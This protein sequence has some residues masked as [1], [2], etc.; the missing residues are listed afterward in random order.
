[1]DP[2]VIV[3]YDPE[4]PQK[5]ER[6]RADILAAA[7]DVIRRIE[8]IGSTS[9]PG[10]AAKPVIDILIGV[11]ALEATMPVLGERLAPLGYQA[12]QFGEAGHG[13]LRRK[14]DGVRTHHVPVYEAATIEGHADLVFRDWLRTHQEDAAAYERLKRDMAVL[15]YENREAYVDSKTEIVREILGRARAARGAS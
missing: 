5:Y 3:E 4:W 11:D 6:A 2:I 15:H 7:G 14:V 8:H 12:R 9:V 10:L 1:M 13:Y